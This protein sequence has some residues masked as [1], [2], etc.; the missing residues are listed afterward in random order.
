MEAL[1]HVAPCACHFL[2]YFATLDLLPIDNPSLALWVQL[3]L[4]VVSLIFAGVFWTTYRRYEHYLTKNNVQT[5][6]LWDPSPFS[7]Y[8]MCYFSPLTMLIIVHTHDPFITLSEILVTEIIC[9]A[10]AGSL[11]MLKNKFLER[12]LTIRKIDEM[13]QEEKD[14]YQTK[15]FTQTPKGNYYSKCLPVRQSDSPETSPLYSRPSARQTAPPQQSLPAQQPKR[16]TRPT[17]KPAPVDED[18]EMM[19][20]DSQSQQSPMRGHLAPKN[21]SPMMEESTGFSPP[22]VSVI[23]EIKSASRPPFDEFGVDSQHLESTLP[24]RVKS[25]TTHTPPAP[26]VFQTKKKRRSSQR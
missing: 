15:Y 16:F 23:D 3:S 20:V 13:A 9:F 14:N 5:L 26:N 1:H 18:A 4:C 10:L 12:E 24:H 22:V 11:L 8:F 6:R 25:R 7:F 19:D 21:A 17:S 2:F